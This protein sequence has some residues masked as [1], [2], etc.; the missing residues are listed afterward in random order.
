MMIVGFG[1]IGLGLVGTLPIAM[2][3]THYPFA[4]RMWQFVTIVLVSTG[5]AVVMYNTAKLLE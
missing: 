4:E 3:L 5:S 2:S 1:L